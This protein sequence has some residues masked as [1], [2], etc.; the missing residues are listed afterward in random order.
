[1]TP[2]DSF[3][4]RHPRAVARIRCAVGLWLLILTAI[5]CGFGY[6]WGLLLLAPA[7]LHFYLAY[8]ALHRAPR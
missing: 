2:T 8:R 3:D 1:M 6:V 7:A 4:R 5:L